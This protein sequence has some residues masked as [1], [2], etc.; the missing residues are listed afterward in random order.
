VQAAVQNA[1][2]W[3]AKEENKKRWKLSREA[4]TPLCTSYRPELDAT[5]ELNPQ[6][7]AHYHSLIEILRLLEYASRPA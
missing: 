5:P 4:E 7:A 2:D 6:E 3:L 1:E